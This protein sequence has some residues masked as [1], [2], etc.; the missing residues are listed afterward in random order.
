MGLTVKE[1]G[2]NSRQCALHAFPIVWSNFM[3]FESVLL[4]ILL[5][6]TGPSWNT[7]FPLVFLRLI[8]R[9]IDVM[10]LKQ[11]SNF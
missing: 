10:M 6:S 1:V 2:K 7:A 5:H 3:H 11:D 8:Y 9:F 4:I